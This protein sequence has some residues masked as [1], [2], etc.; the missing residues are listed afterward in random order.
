MKLSVEAAGI[1]DR[2]IGR[3][4]SVEDSIDY[5]R[6]TCYVRVTFVLE[7]NRSAAICEAS[8]LLSLIDI[9]VDSIIMIG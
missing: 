6:P 8:Q 9:K 7:P 3:K 5:K 1:G 4:I 2:S